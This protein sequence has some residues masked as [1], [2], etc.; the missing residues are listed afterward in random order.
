M[1]VRDWWQTLTKAQRKGLEPMLP[2]LR[3]LAA[4]ADTEMATAAA[5]E[6]QQPDPLADA[7]T[8]EKQAA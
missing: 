3:D 2:E 4:T 1:K 6:E 8:P 5:R 7:F